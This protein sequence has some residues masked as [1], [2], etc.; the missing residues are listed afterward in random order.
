MISGVSERDRDQVSSD[1]RCGRAT[2]WEQ[3]ELTR[4]SCGRGIYEDIIL[5][6]N[7]R[8]SNP[9]LMSV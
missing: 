4:R 6:K 3:L 9:D 1:Q 5:V 2:C 8:M 7:Q